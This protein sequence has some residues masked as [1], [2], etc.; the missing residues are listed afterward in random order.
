MVKGISLKSKE[1]YAGALES[2]YCVSRILMI[3]K[4]LWTSGV[5]LEFKPL[6]ALPAFHIRSA[7]LAVHLSATEKAADDDHMLI[8]KMIKGNVSFCYCY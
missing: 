7:P 2:S 5:R 6:F 1:C 8:L 4:Q 3:K